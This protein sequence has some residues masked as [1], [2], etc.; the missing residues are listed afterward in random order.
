[1]IRDARGLSTVEFAV[2]FIVIVVAFPKGIVGTF[3][4]I[5]P[6]RLSPGKPTAITSHIETAE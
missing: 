3:E 2:L 5:W 4:A 1:M 6:R